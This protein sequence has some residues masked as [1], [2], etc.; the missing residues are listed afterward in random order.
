M[1]LSARSTQLLY[2]SIGAVLALI[3]VGLWIQFSNFGETKK[4][5][6]SEPIASTQTAPPPTPAKLIPTNPSKPSVVT[7]Q[8]TLVPTDNYSLPT[9]SFQELV[10]TSDSTTRKYR[11]RHNKDILIYNFS[12]LTE[13]G[14]TLNRV[15]ALIEDSDASKT[16]ISTEDE[17]AQLHAK[18]NTTAA[19]FNYGHDY[20]SEH[21]ALFFNLALDDQ[22][23]LRDE[24]IALRDELLAESFLIKKKGRY[25]PSKNP[26][27]IISIANTKPEF[28]EK[29]LSTSLRSSITQHEL[30]HGVFFS[31]AEYRRYAHKFWEEHVDKKL[32]RHLEKQLQSLGYNTNNYELIVNEGQAYLIH[33]NDKLFFNVEDVGMT[34]QDLR[35]LRKKFLDNAPDIAFLRDTRSSILR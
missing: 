20:R 10:N 5:S 33:T 12:S 21:L 22:V 25:Y 34:E 23:T 2:I 35:D 3:M 28:S 27:S 31:N 32:H 6:T 11:Y 14:R 7:T 24:E 17:I 18:R 15:M 19:T 26:Q 16:R 4:A 13:Q 29:S 8:K 9:I 30:S 1:S